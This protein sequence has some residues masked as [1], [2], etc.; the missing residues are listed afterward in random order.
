MVLGHKRCH[1]ANGNLSRPIRKYQKL[2]FARHEARRF[3]G[4]ILIPFFKILLN[5]VKST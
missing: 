2:D 5:E 3:G 1:F 4:D